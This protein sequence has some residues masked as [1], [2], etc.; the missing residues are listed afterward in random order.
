MVRVVPLILMFNN[1]VVTTVVEVPCV[2]RTFGMASAIGITCLRLFNNFVGTRKAKRLVL[3]RV[4][5]SLDLTRMNVVLPK[6]FNEI[7]LRAVHMIACP[8]ARGLRVCNIVRPFLL[9]L[10]TIIDPLV[11]RIRP[12]KVV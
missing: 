6:L 8:V 2:P 9:L 7:A 10:Y 1:V 3:S 5:L 11:R 4:S 12:I